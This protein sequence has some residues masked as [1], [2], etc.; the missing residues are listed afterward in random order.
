MAING[1]AVGAV[2]VGGIFLYGAV[3]GKSPLSAGL[4]FLK[5]DSPS[6]VPQTHPINSPSAGSGSG[7]SDSAPSPGSVPRGAPPA[8]TPII[9]LVQQA[10]F[11]GQNADIMTNIVNR[12]SGGNANAFNGNGSTGDL[13][14]GLTQINMRGS[15]GPAR[16]HQFGISKNEDLF[17]PVTNLRAAHILSGGTDFGA[18]GIGPDA[19]RN[20]PAPPAPPNL[21]LRYG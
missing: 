16:R 21:V 3:T 13:S 19:Y 2:V 7:G 6:G 14:Y 15:L 20:V 9:Q 10:G 5:G 11:S 1:V 4:T 12:E 8:G 17:N 18:W